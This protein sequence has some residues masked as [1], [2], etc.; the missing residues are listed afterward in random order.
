MNSSTAKTPGKGPFVAGC[1]T[2]LL[3][4]AVHMIPM[5][6][7]IFTEPTKPPEVEAKRAMVAVAVDIGPFHS[8]WAK[9]N[10][11]LSVSYSALLFFVVAINLVALPAIVAHGRLRATATVNVIFVGIVLSTSVIYQFPPPGVFAL[12]AEAFFVAALV[13]ATGSHG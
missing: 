3:F 8:N 7:D 12:I 1:Y 2:L 10:Q 5:F 6:A 4:S 13:R 9:L 11:L